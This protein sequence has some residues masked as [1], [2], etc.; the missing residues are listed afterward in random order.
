M[1]QVN[2][3]TIKNAA[4]TAQKICMTTCL[5]LQFKIEQPD[6]AMIHDTDSMTVADAD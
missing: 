2:P 5:S 1:A 3:G 6:S 4:I